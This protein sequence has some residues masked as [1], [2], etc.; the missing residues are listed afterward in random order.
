MQRF[1]TLRGTPYARTYSQ[2]Y[3]EQEQYAE[4]LASTGAEAELVDAAPPAVTFADVTADS[5]RGSQAAAP[6]SAGSIVLID[7][8]NDGDLDILESGADGLHLLRNTSGLFADASE[9]AGLATLASGPVSI[10]VAG[11]YDNDGRADIFVDTASGH[12]LLHRETTAR[13]KPRQDP[14]CQ[15]SR[16]GRCLP[17]SSTS[18]T[19]AMSI[20]TLRGNRERRR[21]QARGR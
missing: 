21:T 8:D 5:L 4:A 18:T 15:R 7:I 10:A 1:E 19:T 20:S 17:P 3:L 16:I 11:D 6:G 14:D 9:A 13:S 12:R 2:T